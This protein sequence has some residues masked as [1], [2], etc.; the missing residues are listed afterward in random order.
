MLEQATGVAVTDDDEMY[1]M[2][3]GENRCSAPWCLLCIPQNRWPESSYFL[4]SA[5]RSERAACRVEAVR[6]ADGLM[7]EIPRH[8]TADTVSCKRLPTVTARATR[9]S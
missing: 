3:Q 1:D 8:L 6:L 2:T 9:L 7:G 5:K 4:L